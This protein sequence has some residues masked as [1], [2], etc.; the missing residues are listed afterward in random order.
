MTNM[1]PDVSR[2]LNQKQWVQ[3]TKEWFEIR[4]TLFTASSDVAGILSTRTSTQNK[5][6][7]KKLGWDS[8]PFQGNK[9]TEHGI[10]FEE[11]AKQIYQIKNQ[12]TIYDLGLLK[13][14]TIDCLGASPDGICSTGRLIEIKVPSAR[15]PQLGIIPKKYWI[16]MQVQMQVCQ[17]KECDFLQ[18]VITEYNSYKDFIQDGGRLLTTN[19]KQKGIIGRIGDNALEVG[20]KYFYPKLEWSVEEKLHWLKQQRI[21]IHTATEEDINF[22]YWQLEMYQC[23]T[24]LRDDNWWIEQKVEE[25]LKL[26][27]ECV[28]QKKL[29]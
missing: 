19:S 9:Y 21:Q 3:R 10:K 26:C 28:Q 20:N 25:K 5:V 7:C 2:L 15:R 12:C 6:I 17:V 23:E 1:H 8:A 4:S 27:W 29:L 16:Q 13:H 22:D 24:V 14:P 18:C 11:I